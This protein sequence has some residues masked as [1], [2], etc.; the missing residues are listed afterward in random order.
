MG[1]D[2][3]LFDPVVHLEK[4]NLATLTKVCNVHQRHQQTLLKFISCFHTNVLENSQ[5]AC[6]SESERTRRLGINKSATTLGV[7]DTDSP[8]KSSSQSCGK[9]GKDT[10]HLLSRDV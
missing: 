10:D 1:V 7:R 9:V 4:D 3:L 8:G 5:R 6:I 2:P